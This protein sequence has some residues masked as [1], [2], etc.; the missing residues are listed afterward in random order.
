MARKTVEITITD[1]GRDKGKTYVL[2]EM[3]A[4][5]SEWWGL[6]FLTALCNSNVELPQELINAGLAGIAALGVRFV[7]GTL[8]KAEMKELHDEMFESC[9]TFVPDP[10]RPREAAFMRGKGG[11]VP[12]IDDDVEEQQTLRRLREEILR[13]HLDFFPPAV[14]SILEIIV[15]TATKNI[16]DTLTSQPPSEVSS[17]PDSQP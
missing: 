1:E 16:T 2:T 4:R 11:G 3:P 7:L 14:R 6:R 9:I 5:Q 15:A 17:L 13:M 10:S 8:G 12:M